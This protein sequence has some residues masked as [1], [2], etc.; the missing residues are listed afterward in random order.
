MKGN[1]R[2]V[3]SIIIL[4]SNT[5]FAADILSI[6]IQLP[7]NLDWQQITDEENETQYMR[8]WIPAGM[9]ISGTNWLIVEQKFTLDRKT[10]S[11]NFIENMLFISKSKCTDVKFNGPEKLK[12]KGLTTHW[13]RL[14]CAKVKGSDYGTFTDLRVISSGKTI[15]VVTSELRIP[16]SSVAGVMSF[17]N[18]LEKIREFMTTQSISSSFVRK[19][20]EIHKI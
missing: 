8:E 2:R 11:K 14:M 10:S 3:L 18:D 1:L 5:A 20:V 17:D 16:P 4:M 15:Y 9:D 7:S 13:A 12:I 6:S 19:N